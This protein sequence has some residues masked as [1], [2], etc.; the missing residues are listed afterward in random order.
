MEGAAAAGVAAP[1]LSSPSPRIRAGPVRVV[2]KIY[3][4]GGSAGC[5]QVSARAS[6]QADSS[7]ATVSF[8]PV[9]KD[10]TSA[11]AGAM[12]P[13]KTN[14]CKLDWC[15]LK[16]DSCTRI[17]DKEVKPLLD[18]I[19]SG[20]GRKNA[21]VV[22]CGAAA[23]THLI[24]GSR[25]HPGLLIMA[26]KQILDSAKPTGTVVSISSYQV[27][28][29]S[30]VFDLLE[31]KDSEVIVREDGVGRT[32]LKGLSRVDIKSIDEFE[33][34]CCGGDNNQL[35]SR[36]HQGFIIYISKSDQHGRE[37]A[38]TKMHFL[39]LGG[40]V[41]TKQNNYGG[42][43]LTPS[44]SKKS[45]YAVMDVVQALNSNQ[46]F[47]PY[48]K[49]KV[50]H[51]L[52]DSLSKTSVAV[53]IS[54]LDEISCQDAVCTLGLASRSS[55]V[56]NEQCY[57]LS[58]GTRNSSKSN[59]KLSVSTKNLSRSLL[60]A[61][62]HRSSVFQ[63][64]DRTQ[65]INSVVK[66]SGT[67]NANKRSEATMN[68]AKKTSSVSASINVKRSGIKSV[69]SGRNLFFPNTNSSKED[70]IVVSTAVRKAEGGQPSPRMAI[71][72]PPPT[73]TCDETEKAAGVV[74]SEMQVVVPCSKEELVPRAIQVP[75]PTEACDETEKAEGVVSSE[76]QV[77]VPC[78]K[79]E[80]VSSSM[81]DKDLLC[82]FVQICSSS[83]LPAEN[84]YTDLGMTSSDVTSDMQEKDQSSSDS[85]PE[86]SYGMT[87]SS[88]VTD[89]FVEN[90]PVSITDHL[91]KISNSLKVLST[92]PVNIITTQKT[93]EPKTPVAHLKFGH[94]EDP[95]YSLRVRST[96]IKKSLAQ[97]CLTFLNSANKEQLKSLKGIGEKRAN[98]ILELREDSPEP[99]KEI[100]DLRTIIGMN[101]K[102]I[103]SMMS[104]MVLDSEMD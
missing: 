42:G 101:K 45:L 46:S 78:S 83:E 89:E 13:R 33:D 41:D 15:Y 94:A 30:H 61:I 10:A 29:D 17:F 5:F 48:R 49:S 37:C 54:C 43:G 68:S 82:A 11:A 28:Q 66:A 57:S 60:P 73:E 96:G 9:T 58:L 75:P 19:L 97:E 36:G 88:D 72:A 23:K 1:N 4:G 92:M 84:S 70:K 44:N 91:K 27:L 6:D 18:A 63:K 32:H 52:Q 31:P 76:M 64:N 102:E 16:D 50:T 8:V 74:S 100:D 71:Q 2:A 55:Q 104:G 7:S 65:S 62:Q 103:K 34:L 59:V 99:L 69:L 56:V 21:C 53:L 77:V 79:E 38:V 87:Y 3:P 93:D 98:F 35:Q 24:K 67:P 95:Q 22:T 20:A 14:E 85:F 51:I 80:L 81:Q 25:D 86:N 40:F 39:D 26:M 12:T 47:I 90:T